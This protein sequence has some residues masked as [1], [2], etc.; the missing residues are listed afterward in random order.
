MYGFHRFLGPELGPGITRGWGP[1]NKQSAYPWKVGQIAGFEV[2]SLIFN[3]FHRFYM[4]LDGFVW[5][6]LILRG[7]GMPGSIF[8]GFHRF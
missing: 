7:S 5:I 6:S 1:L 2:P 8:N 4:I 3:G